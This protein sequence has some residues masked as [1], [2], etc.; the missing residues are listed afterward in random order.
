MRGPGSRA[1]IKRWKSWET[2]TGDR[3]PSM[4]PELVPA[5]A[6]VLILGGGVLVGRTLEL[7]LRSADYG[8]RYLGEPCLDKPGL[9]EGGNCLMGFAS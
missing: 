7:L 5:S 6:R 1:I 4:A 3:R 9:G 2:N 8:V